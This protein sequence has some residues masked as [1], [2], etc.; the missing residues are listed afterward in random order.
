MERELPMQEFDIVNQYRSNFEKSELGRVRA[1]LPLGKLAASFGLSEKRLGKNSYFDPEGKVALM[2]LKAYTGL[3]D[4]LLI[5]NLNGNVYMQMFCGVM[6]SP[7]SPITNYKIVSDIRQE[8]SGHMHVDELQRVLAKEWR[9]WMRNLEDVHMDA[10]CYESR[11]RY[12]TDVKV[13]WECV[14]WIQGLT[15]KVCRD[16]GIWRPKNKYTDVATAQLAYSRQ[17]KHN[18]RQTHHI[19]MR[20]L[21]LLRKQLGQLGEILAGKDIGQILKPL[22][23]SRLRTA[24]M[25]LSQQSAHLKSGEQRESIP[26]R[27]V[28]LAKPYVRPIVRGKENK[29]VEFG[30]KVNNFLVDGVSFIDKISFNAF[31][32]CN[33]LEICLKKHRKLF[34]VQAS[35]VGADNCYATNANRAVCSGMV[36]SFVPKGRKLAPDNAKEVKRRELAKIRATTMEGSFGNQKEHYSL[37]RIGACT[38]KTEKLWIFFGIHTANAVL[39]AEKRRQTEGDR[40]GA[41]PKTA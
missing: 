34:G 12:P 11:M 37:K 6:V 13:V 17:R 23:I 21:K 4:R 32:E 29:S 26:N 16:L 30:A 24:R 19:Q 5:E 3:S 25:I 2:F 36:T 33:R 27:I 18:K 7:E 22:Q 40:A 38:R 10:T 35:G 9:P 41:M 15:V 8:M 20:L 14:E 28:S 1:V 31:N 39:I